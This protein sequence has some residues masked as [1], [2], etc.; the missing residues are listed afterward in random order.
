MLIHTWKDFVSNPDFSSRLV[1]NWWSVVTPEDMVRINECD[2]QGY[3]LLHHAAFACLPSVV[4]ELIDNGADVNAA[5]PSCSY[6]PHHM[7]AMSIVFMNPSCESV[8]SDIQRTIRIL[9]RKG[10][11][12]TPAD[13][14]TLLQMTHAVPLIRRRIAQM[15]IDELFHEFKS[16]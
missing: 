16:A 8:K 13:G 2:A 10:A 6:K 7:I 3:T 5:T 11:V 4:C 14:M 15:N 9:I 1:R 12:D